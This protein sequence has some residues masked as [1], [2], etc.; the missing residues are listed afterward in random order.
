LSIA[1]PKPLDYAPGTR[2]QYSNTGYVV[3]GMILE[4]AAGEPLM[5]F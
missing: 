3:A 5:H 1:G 4:K 2:W